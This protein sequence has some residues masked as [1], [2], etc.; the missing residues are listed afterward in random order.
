MVWKVRRKNLVSQH[1][2]VALVY[3]EMLGLDEAVGYLKRE[4]VPEEI[5]ER[6]LF[7]DRKRQQPSASIR[8]QAAQLPDIACRRKNHIHDAIVE[9]ALKVERKLGTD[10]ALILLRNEEVPEAVAARVIAPGPRQLRAR[11]SSG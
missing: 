7:T 10:M 2:E 9:A 3:K 11:K 1:I 5:V 6:V 8:D 4:S